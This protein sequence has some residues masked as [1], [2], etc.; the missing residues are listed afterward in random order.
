MRG[1]KKPVAA[2]V[3]R[4]STVTLKDLVNAGGKEISLGSTMYRTALGTLF[5]AIEEV[6]T[7]GTFNFERASVP[8]KKTQRSDERQL[9]RSCYG[10]RND[11]SEALAERNRT[12][13]H[14][15]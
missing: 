13:R 2:L 5:S 10:A 12:W 11:V 14:K 3:G 4:G 9:T 7:T 1:S 15:M 8:Y 6:Q